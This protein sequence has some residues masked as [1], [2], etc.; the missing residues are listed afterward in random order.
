[1]AYKEV[2]LSSTVP[3]LSPTTVDLYFT[4]GD[5]ILFIADSTFHGRVII[6]QA[7]VNFNTSQHT[8]WFEFRPGE[9][10]RTDAVLDNNNTQIEYSVYADVPGGLVKSDAP[11]RIIIH[12]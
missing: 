11:P 5:K 4:N 2:Y 3:Y 6:D 1:M 8:Y 10:R 12:H 7:N 9:I